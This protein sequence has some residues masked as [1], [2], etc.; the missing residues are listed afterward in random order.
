M[1]FPAWRASACRS[2]SDDMRYTIFFFFTIIALSFSANAQTTGA[3][4]GR[5]T[6]GSDKSPLHSV[7]VQLVELSRSA[8]TD[9][10]GVYTFVNVPQGTYRIVAHLEGFSDTKDPVTVAAGQTVTKN[11]EMQLAGVRAEVT[12]TASGA[13]QTPFESIASVSS[14]DSTALAARGGISLGEALDNAP[15]VAKRSAGPGAS[16]PVIRGFDGDRVKIASD[17]IGVA[18][19]GS[20]SG[21]HAEPVDVLAADRIE[22]VKGPATL[23]YGSNAMGGVVNAVSGH[24]EGAHPG[25]RGFLSGIGSSVDRQASAAG[26][27]EYGTDR[28]VAWGNGSAQRTGD[29]V[30]GGNFGKVQNSSVR[31]AAGSA[32][33][34]YYGKKAFVN[35]SYSEYQ[36]RYG[37]PLDIFG[38][39]PEVRSIRMRR[40]DLR[41]NF[42]YS[43]LSMPI[44]NIKI[45]ADLSRY[46]HYEMQGDEIGTTFRNNVNSL[47]GMFEQR[48]AGRLT[49]RFGFDA[50]SRKFSAVGTETLINGPIKQTETSV[51]GLEELKFDR[52]VLQF[53]GRIERNA[54]DPQ[55][56]LLPKREFTGA[57]GSVGGRIGLWN[58]GAFV[59]NYSHSYRA[60]A[61]DELYNNGPHDGTLLFEVGNPTLMPEVSDGIDLSIRHQS[62]RF[63]AEAN[64][65][66]YHIRN[67]VFLAPS[68]TLDSG[69][70]FEIANYTQG[71]SRF[72]GTEL[73]LDVRAN[74]FLNL[75][76]G[77]DQ[78][79]AELA[80]GTPLPRIAP[81]RGRVG[82]DI[83]FRSI[84]VKPE[85]IG[86]ARQDRTFT[87][88]TPTAGYG[89]MNLNGMYVISGKHT[90]QIFSVAAYNLTNK[91]YYDHISF[92]K[93]LAPEAG[94]GVRFSYTIRY[95]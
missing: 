80:N 74:K 66:Y 43:D 35:G 4:T 53:G 45:T 91:L 17:G 18:S 59:A 70:G 22:I 83:H 76:S 3:I 39:D 72:A 9:D 69:S 30:A 46:R 32:G 92:I 60:P 24:D 57:S 75:T 6:Y 27:M 19:L 63:K 16:R 89:I 65:F 95:F 33:F 55:D 90:A 82:L 61:L 1:A 26:G 85:F 29:R 78:V 37:I 12:V 88:E 79:S 56:V 8:A 84:A 21:D 38:A 40:G 14:V 52:V 68:G 67:F 23:L 54:Y 42:G 64:Y 34:G 2:G 48:K 50:S 7:S 25:L 71:N 62:T 73:S 93:R 77:L 20:Q 49:G 11:I 41:L 87:N 44:T 81:L 86:V 5:V 47:R 94:R 31:S 58:G 28:W 51:F 15:G 10:Q 13:E 36:S